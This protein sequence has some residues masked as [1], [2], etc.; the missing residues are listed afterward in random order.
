MNYYLFILILR[1]AF[2]MEQFELTIDIIF[3]M[4]ILVLISIGLILSYFGL[5][6][7]VLIDIGLKALRNL[8]RDLFALYGLLRFQFF[9][10]KCKHYDK[11][12]YDLFVESAKKHPNKVA[13]YFKDER[14]TYSK[15]HQYTIQVSNC[16]YDKGFHENDEVCLLMSNR[17]EYVG[18][19]L[20]LS[21]IGVVSALINTNNKK[22]LLL[23]TITAIN[24]KAVVFE[25]QYY[26][27][28]LYDNINY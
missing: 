3:M 27:G 15:L 4:L 8:P 23:N 26:N 11:S 28:Q 7:P 2:T 12:V 17:P 6:V 5:T 16:F 13:L 22:D 24:A 14:W 9:L 19:W 20:G 21:A 1:F 18:L 25:S 10:F